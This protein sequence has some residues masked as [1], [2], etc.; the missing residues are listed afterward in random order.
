MEVF[1]EQ[2]GLFKSPLLA[3]DINKH[4]NLCRRQDGRESVHD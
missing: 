2:A 4:E 3:G 1:K